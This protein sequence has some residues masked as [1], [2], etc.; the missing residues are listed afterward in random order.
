MEH[1]QIMAT[2]QIITTRLTL[3]HMVT[4]QTITTIKD[5]IIDCYCTYPLYKNKPFFV[6]RENKGK[7]RVHIGN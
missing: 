4:I 1:Q 2:P 7:G 3:I 6:V 5:L